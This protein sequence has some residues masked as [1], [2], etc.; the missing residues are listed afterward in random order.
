MRL[1]QEALKKP[2]LTQPQQMQIR[3]LQMRVYK[4]NNMSMMGGMGC[5]PLLIQLPIMMGIYQAVAYSKELAASSF[6]GIS[7][8]QRSI[9]LTIIA[10][11]LYVVQGYLSMV[12][13]PEEQKKAM[14]MTLILSPAMTFFISISA[15]GALALYF[16]VG[17]LIA[18]LQQLITTFVIMPKVKR[19]VAAELNERPLK[20]VVTQET[21]DNIL[22][23]TSSSNSTP[24]ANKDLHQDLRARNA[25]KQKRPN[26][27]DKD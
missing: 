7:L 26:D 23:T 22:N 2:G 21:I 12:G 18:I 10:T 20:V 3:Q 1:I 19:D 15:P 17:G 27:S 25:G 9:I 6:F 24:E 14:Q 4:E 11:L 13:I 5:L 16:L 8:G